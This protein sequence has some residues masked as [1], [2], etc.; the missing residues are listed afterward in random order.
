VGSTGSGAPFERVVFGVGG[1]VLAD[2]TLPVAARVAER[3]DVPLEL[4][5]VF[6]RGDDELPDARAQLL[7]DLAGRHDLD[8]AEVTVLSGW[9]VPRNLADHVAGQVEPL[10]C[11]AAS[12]RSRADELF[13]GSVTGGVLHRVTCPVLVIGREVDTTADPFDGPVLVCTDG[14]DEAESIVPLA[15]AWTQWSGQKPWV[16]SQLA[17]DIDVDPAHETSGVHRVAEQLGTDAEWEVLRGRRPGR[18]IAE[19]AADRG[20]GLIIMA[21]H[22]QSALARIAVGSTA[23]ATM[24]RAPCPVLVQR[25]TSV[26]AH[27]D[28]GEDGEEQDG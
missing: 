9:S 11:L 2:Q 4:A 10:L 17:P 3:A 21:T 26:E 1:P 22:G 6:A 12:V 13:L 27:Q 5:T 24:E 7:E 8:D 23:M 15:R 19:L 20:A 25:P 18:A 16:V 28:E 14:S